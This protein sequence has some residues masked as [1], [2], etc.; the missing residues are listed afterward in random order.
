MFDEA[1]RIDPSMR[2][3]TTTW[4]MHSRRR[5]T[6]RPL[7]PRMGKPF[8]SRQVLQAHTQPRQCTAR[9]G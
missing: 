3:R 4:A 5:V 2:E 6:L 1:L 9:T 8:S 7:P